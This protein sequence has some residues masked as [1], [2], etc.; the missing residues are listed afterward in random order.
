MSLFR[1]PP[2][3]RSATAP[4]RLLTKVAEFDLAVCVNEARFRLKIAVDD[5][6][7]VEVG[8]GEEQ[9]C[10]CASGWSGGSYRAR[11]V[12]D[13]RYYMSSVERRASQAGRRVALEAGR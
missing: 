9:L 5:R 1:P 4:Y 12:L 2:Q 8:E 13:T 10:G 6:V 3:E 7:A 11:A